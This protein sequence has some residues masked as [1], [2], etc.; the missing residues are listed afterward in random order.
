SELLPI[1]LT[2]LYLPLS[3]L[4]TTTLVEPD[5]F[6]FCRT[7]ITCNLFA[8]ILKKG[9]GTPISGASTKV[10]YSLQADYKFKDFFV[11]KS[12]AGYDF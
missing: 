3:F 11:T 9:I 6:F 10:F 5:L 12:G 1:V 2:S 4:T 8:K 7:N